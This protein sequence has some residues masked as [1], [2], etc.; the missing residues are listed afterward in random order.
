MNARKL[1]QMTDAMTERVRAVYSWA[2]NYPHAG[3][4]D[5]S[6]GLE[7]DGWLAGVKREA[8]EEFASYRYMPRDVRAY[9]KAYLETEPARSSLETK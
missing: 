2:D 9:V 6:A 1:P 8:L 3:E 4:H 7:F 5:E